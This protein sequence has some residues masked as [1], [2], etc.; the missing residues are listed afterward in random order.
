[1][2]VSEEEESSLLLDEKLI[3]FMDQL[4]SLE[5]KRATLN[6]LIE[7]GW[8]SMSKA[9][10]SMGNKQVSALQYA[11]EIEPLVCVNARTQDNG[12]VQFCTERP[13]Q[14]SSKESAKDLPIED[15]GP[16]EEGVRRRNKPKKDIREKEASEDASSKK[17][18]EANPVRKSD[19]DPQQDP[20][21]WF[22]ILVPQSL[23]QAQSSFKQVIELSAEIATLQI[24]VLNTRQE[25]K[26]CLK[27][28]HT[29]Q[30]KGSATESR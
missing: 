21:K 19:H 17:A 1:M 11:S 16:Q 13:T 12:E 18:P 5:E 26:D 29:L 8:F 14:K 10:Y 30:K 22:G 2:G 24:A 27:N 7:Q 4:E 3:R 25:L 9:R 28:K 23:K 20:L 15:V 6:S